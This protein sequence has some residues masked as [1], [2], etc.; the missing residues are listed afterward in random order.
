[1]TTGIGKSFSQGLVLFYLLRIGTRVISSLRLIVLARFLSPTDFGL[2][3]VVLLVLSLLEILST[4]GFDQAL[5]QKR[6]DVISYFDTVWYFSIV[7]GL[8][9]GAFIYILAPV[10]GVFFKEPLSV[11]LLRVMALSPVLVGFKSPG[12]IEVNRELKFKKLVIFDFSR[13]V[14]VAVV[15]GIA[16]YLVRNA[17]ALIIASLLDSIL[18]SLSS[19][20]IYP[21]CPGFGFKVDKVK[22]LWGYGRWVFGSKIAHYLFNDGDDWIVGR[23]LGSQALG[24]YQ[25]A[26]NFGCA[27]MTEITGVFSR[28]AFPT[29]SSIQSDHEKSRLAYLKIL[30]IIMFL[31]TP[32][33]LGIFSVAQDGVA[34]FLGSKW[35]P[36]VT[37]LQIL[38][39]WG[40][41]RSFRA[42]TGPL[43]LANG[44]PDA[45]TK[46]TI[47][48]VIILAVLI[49]PFSNRWGYIGTSWA[50]LLASF[51]ELPLI[52]YSMTNIMGFQSWDIIRNILQPL[53]A[54]IPMVIMVF[55][56]K[57]FL[58]NWNAILRLSVL[59]IT[60]VLIYTVITYL[61]DKHFKWG[62]LDSAKKAFEYSGLRLIKGKK[63]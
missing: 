11:P 38:V 14:I 28:V 18:L 35:L 48:K 51:L 6:T 23:L 3:G 26:Y 57:N 10:A 42:T 1:M 44:R 20:F 41:I 25:T 46:F 19:F 43:L 12:L 53:L 31:S 32:V 34:I 56:E 15:A 2:M 9:L 61:A 58:T 27:P 7:R 45:V 29:F 60:G 24:F 16:A 50:V 47:V 39:F 59:C 8:I 33:A 13:S 62:L 17:Y 4:T 36:M 52:I 37:S 63:G 40:W 5:I 55:I 21:Y 54:G 22:E 30:Q 49:F